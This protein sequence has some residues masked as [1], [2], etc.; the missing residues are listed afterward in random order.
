MNFFEVLNRRKS[1]RSYTSAPVNPQ[2]ID[3][4]IEAAMTAPV[5]RARFEDM[6][7]TVITDKSLLA[8]IAQNASKLSGRDGNPLFDAPVLIVVSVKPAGDAPQNNEFSS[9]AIIIH[10]MALTATALELG[11]CDIWGAI[12]LAN[13]NPELIAR[14]GLPEGF[15]PTAGI[16]IGVT[17]DP[18]PLREP[19]KNKIAI[20]FVE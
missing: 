6:H 19:D 7:L 15:V 20:N 14:L 18:M 16:V 12:A 4:I 11:S 2:L 9:A 3:R 1:I 8:A 17:L 5:A 13:Q 10:N